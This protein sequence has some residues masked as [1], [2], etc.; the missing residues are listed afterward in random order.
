MNHASDH[1]YQGFSPLPSAAI[2]GAA[3]IPTHID[4]ARIRIVPMTP[5]AG[6]PARMPPA[7]FGGE[8]SGM[9]E[10]LGTA[11]EG[12]GWDPRSP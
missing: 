12:C 4:A 5:L 10:D 9:D 11:A 8:A 3:A 2:R 6:T 1:L 7:E